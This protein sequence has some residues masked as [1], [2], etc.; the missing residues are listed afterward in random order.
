LDLKMNSLHKKYETNVLGA[1]IIYMPNVPLSVRMAERCLETCESVG[2]KAELFE[3]FDGTTGEVKVPEHLKNQSWIKW[4]KVTDHFQSPTE[5]ACSLS[6]IALWVKCMEEEKPLI[7][8]E[9][10][11]IMV[12][13]YNVHP[14]YNVISYL[15]CH[16]QMGQVNLPATPIHSSINKNWHFINRAHA[17]CIDPQVSKR[18]FLNVLDRG[19]FETSDV[20]IKCDDVAIVQNGFYAYDKSDGVSTLKHKE[21]TDHRKLKENN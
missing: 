1:F 14:F 8:L 21:G 13:P 18:L 10:D 20:M 17:Y 7:V 9:H 3:G 12:K 11:A 6:H 5:I 4:M 15:G 16:E 2:Q 19:I